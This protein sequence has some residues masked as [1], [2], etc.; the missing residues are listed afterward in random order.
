MEHNIEINKKTNLFLLYHRFSCA[1]SFMKMCHFE[2]TGL[3]LRWIQLSLMC[4][5]YG[6]DTIIFISSHFFVINN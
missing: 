6:H 4:V 1:V 5:P 2:S 3:L